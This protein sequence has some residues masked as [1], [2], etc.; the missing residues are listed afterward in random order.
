MAA[1]PQN[2]KEPQNPSQNQQERP[3]IEPEKDLFSW[4]AQSRPFQ[5]RGREFWVR[6][7]AIASVFGLILFVVEGVMPVILMIAIIFLYYILSTVKPEQMDYRITNKGVKIA[8]RTT[9]WL[10]MTRF[11]F[12]KRL[13]SELLVFETLNFPGRVELVIN[14][15]DKNKLKEIISKYILEEEAPPTRMDKAADWFSK[16]LIKA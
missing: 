1:K 10:V 5:Q 11:W 15:K 7:I 8:N 12:S 6:V 9:E 13:D 16:R 14:P 3:G 4:S 2:Q